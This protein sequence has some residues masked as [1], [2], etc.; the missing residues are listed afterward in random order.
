M[1]LFT[2]G[3]IITKELFNLRNERT[4]DTQFPLFDMV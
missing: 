4:Q 1:C 3:A 2:V